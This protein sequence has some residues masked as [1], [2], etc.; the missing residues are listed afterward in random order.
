[1]S[2][3]YWL[4]T[5]KD[6]FYW[7]LNSVDVRIDTLVLPLDYARAKDQASSTMNSA[8]K[9]SNTESLVDESEGQHSDSSDDEDGL[10]STRK[11]NH[12]SQRAYM[13]SVLFDVDIRASS[14]QVQTKVSKLFTVAID[15]F[16]KNK[17]YDLFV[18]YVWRPD[19]AKDDAFRVFRELNFKQD[20]VKIQFNRQFRIVAYSYGLEDWTVSQ[21]TADYEVEEQQIDL[22]YSEDQLSLKRIVLAN[23]NNYFLISKDIMIQRLHLEQLGV[24]SLRLDGVFVDY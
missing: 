5:V 18:H 20:L 15:Q 16:E 12:E 13:L 19:L 22:I 23:T 6:T 14:K 4:Q 17:F 9:Q 7:L 8:Y 3:F 1:M 21:S 2:P 10:Y 24:K 11:S